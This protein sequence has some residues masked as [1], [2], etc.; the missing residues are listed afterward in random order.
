[1]VSAAARI[2]LHRT[3]QNAGDLEIGGELSGVPPG[4]TRFVA[5]AD[6]LKLP[7][8]TY[9]VADD[10]NFVGTVR[11]TGVALQKL[12][13]LLGAAPG[14]KMI[15]AICDDLYAAHYPA[16]YLQAHHPLL[17]L[18]INGSDPAHWPLGAD[19]AAMGP[20]LVSHAKF[21]PSFQILAHKDEPQVP[22]GVVRL[23]FDR[24]AK[25]YAP[26]QPRGPAADTEQVQQ[27]FVIAKQ[28]CFRCHARDG[29]G[30]RKSKRSWDRIA[31]QSVTDPT[32]FDDYVRNPQAFNPS[33]QMAASPQYDAATLAALRAYF[34][35]FAETHP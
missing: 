4:E 15:T 5:Y 7:L 29:E 13:A 27:G 31:R 10:T 21:T 34:R 1:M 18:R 28:N 14:A 32:A 24:E 6:L 19:H 20:Y 9:T 8:E 22:W 12:P 26:I 30:G 25:V 33:S 3:R 35:P 11:I 2:K 23:D 16:E 17:V